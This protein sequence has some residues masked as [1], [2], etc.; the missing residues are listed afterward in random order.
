MVAHLLIFLMGDVQ[1]FKHL[2]K[3]G[4]VGVVVNYWRK[5]KPSP[6]SKVSVSVAGPQPKAA[7]CRIVITHVQLHQ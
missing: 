7:S 3:E 6:N 2:R 5:P 4:S 1:I